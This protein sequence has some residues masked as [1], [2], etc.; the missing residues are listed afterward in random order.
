MTRSNAEA[1]INTAPDAS[2]GDGFTSRLG[3][4]VVDHGRFRRYCSGDHFGA[5][6]LLTD[7]PQP[8]AVVAGDR[9]A[10]VLMLQRRIFKRLVGAKSKSSEE[11]RQI[12]VHSGQLEGGATPDG[13]RNAAR[14]AAP[15]DVWMDS[16]E[17]EEVSP[18]YP[19]LL[20]KI[21]TVALDPSC[22]GE[23]YLDRR[24]RLRLYTVVCTTITATF[25][26]PMAY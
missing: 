22:Q 15:E 25:D 11:L 10:V 23:S 5:V 17:E 3:A 26:R 8:H 20:E 13:K 6:S 19:V 12:L 4:P 2:A 16:E 21:E 18:P 14:V 7:A 1:A 9:G 24:L